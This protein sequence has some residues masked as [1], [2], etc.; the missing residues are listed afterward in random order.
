MYRRRSVR[1]VVTGV[2]AAVAAGTLSVLTATNAFAHGTPTAPGSRGYLCYTDAHWTG[3]DLD[4]RNAACKAAVDLGGKQPL[5]DWFGTL[6]SDGGGRMAGFIPDGQLCSGGNTK[7]AG[8]DLPRADWPATRLTSG[9][10]STVHY[11]AWAAHP[12]QMRLFVTKD[13]YDPTKALTWNDLESVPF[14]TWNE[15]VPNGTGEY[16]WDVTWPTGKTGRHIVYSVWARTDSQETFYGCSDVLFDGG[17]GEVVGMGTSTSTT[18]PPPV[19]TTTPPPVTTT[20]PPP[21][22]TTTPPPVTTTPPPVT[23]TSAPPTTGSSTC[24]AQVS[25][26]TPWSGGYQGSVT[27]LN[28]GAALNPWKVTFAL[29]AGTTLVNGWNATVTQSGTTVTAAA[30]SWNTA[31]GTGKEVS[32]GFVANGSATPPPSNV[33]L[34]GIACSGAGTTPTTT[35]TT[36]T[37]TP[38]TPSPSTS[39]PTTPTTPTPT[40]PSPTTPSPTTSSPTTPPGGS[41]LSDG[42]ETQTGATLSGPW[43]LNQPDCSGTGTV[44]VDR[45]VAHS[46]SASL[47]VT[48]GGGYCDHVFAQL[49]TDLRTVGTSVYA[50]MYVR[51]TTAL[52]TGHVTMAAFNDANDGNR[53]VRIGGQG[54]AL[55]WNRQS[56]DATL[57]A[58]SPNGIA[59]S[60]PLPTG[61]W[62]CLEVAVNQSAGT[63]DTWLNGTLVPGLHADGVATTDIDGQWY[64]KAWRPALTSFGLGWESYSGATDTLWYD[65][66]A[67]SN[68]RIGC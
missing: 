65:D 37:T 61:S 29:P 30:P 33:Q 50:R 19:T 40:T 67:I 28:N 2:I 68:T 35:P 48:G 24:Q 18:T 26:G 58:Q 44:A 64:N 55:Q 60:R 22:T 57:P 56:D 54:Q 42:F 43:K 46:G 32:V 31:L 20:T 21:V 9:G 15:T 17:N 10:K 52:P 23:T 38:T 63:A 16:Y 27:V 53:A 34:N 59:Q 51:H 14:S 13:G 5:W 47:K 6:R 66:V 8:L 62:Q 12:G 36:P 11:A 39:T 41:A 49:T 7:Y 3:G 4:P 25:T 45:T 1:A